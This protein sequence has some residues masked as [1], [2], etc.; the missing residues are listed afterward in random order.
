MTL[1]VDRCDLRTLDEAT[2]A[3]LGKLT[4][5]SQ[6][7]YSGKI[8]KVTLTSA[9]G[10][11]LDFRGAPPAHLALIARRDGEIVGWAIV[12]GDTAQIMLFVHT[13]HRR[14]GIGTA[15]VAE[16]R[17]LEPDL[18]G[19]HWDAASTGFFGRTCLPRGRQIEHIL[20]RLKTTT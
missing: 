17:A 3:T 20:E 19:S 10:I 14:V 11:R 18:W 6:P 13:S 1:R 2:V 4:L 8:V 15:L 12:V 16:A 7:L 5:P 9:M